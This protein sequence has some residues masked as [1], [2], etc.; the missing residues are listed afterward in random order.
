[1]VGTPVWFRLCSGDRRAS[2][3]LTRPIT[4]ASHGEVIDNAERP[5]WAGYP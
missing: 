2:G 3:G 1:M 5:W 4:A